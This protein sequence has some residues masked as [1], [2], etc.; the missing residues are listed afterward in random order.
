MTG[1][2]RLS[3]DIPKNREIMPDIRDWGN[4]F[5]RDPGTGVP[6]IPSGEQ[7]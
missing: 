4:P 3:R 5:G 1:I 6:G 7:E 2:I